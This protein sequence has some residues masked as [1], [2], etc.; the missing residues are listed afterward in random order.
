MMGR[1]A[2]GVEGKCGKVT[3]F[4]FDESSWTIAHVVICTGWLP[5]HC[6]LVSPQD[7]STV[8][9]TGDL[10]VTLTKDQID[11]SWDVTRF[12]TIGDH[13]RAVLH[14]SYGTPTDEPY[15]SRSEPRHGTCSRMEVELAEQRLAED[16]GQPARTNLLR[17]TA[18]MLGYAV[19]DDQGTVGSLDDFL[20]GED[21]WTVHYLVLNE[22]GYATAAKKVLLPTTWID[23]ICWE[24]S[25][26]LLK[27]SRSALASAQCYDP[28]AHGH[29]TT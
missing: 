14:A 7:V 8:S 3:D 23:N 10:M 17:G 27:T 2:Q 13:T 16:E 18:E 19:E 24:D 26:V 21:D 22:R 29:T 4:Y 28:A 11:Q 5:R 9:P 12:E 15:P 25:M 6:F 1:R 20:L